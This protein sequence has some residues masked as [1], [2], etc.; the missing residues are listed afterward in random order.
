VIFG[1]SSF[2]SPFS[3]TSLTG[4]N[5]FRVDWTYGSGLGESI[6]MGGDINGDGTSDLVLG[7]AR[8]SNNAGSAYVIFGKSN[9]TSP[10]NLTSINGV[11]GFV[12]NGI[13]SYGSLGISVSSEGD[14]NGDGI[15]DL[16][17][18]AI[19]VSY[20]TGV[21][22]VGTVYAIFGQ[23]NF[24]SPFSLTSLNGTNGFVVNGISNGGWLGNSVSNEGDINGDGI[25]DLVLGAPSVSYQ[26]GAAYVIFGRR[27]FTSPF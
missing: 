24:T 21:S 23:S 13:S 16:L 17:L 6:S 8:D 19:G 25:A 7:A 18:G 26:S 2:T 20:G 14:I 1:Q 27:Y 9:F 15:A 12:V 5:G 10:I 4:T 11:N 3:L 22:D